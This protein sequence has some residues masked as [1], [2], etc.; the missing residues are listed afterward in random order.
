[1]GGYCHV[2]DLAGRRRLVRPLW[3]QCH[4]QRNV[5]VLTGLALMFIVEPNRPRSVFRHLIGLFCSGLCV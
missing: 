4:V 1:M 3:Y 2:F 5:H